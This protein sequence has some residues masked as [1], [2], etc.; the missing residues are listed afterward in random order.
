MLQYSVFR[1]VKDS[2]V[3]GIRAIR[4]RWKRR[5]N[6]RDFCYDSRT[7]VYGFNLSWPLPTRL[8]DLFTSSIDFSSFRADTGTASLS[9]RL[10]NT[11]YSDDVTFFFLAYEQIIK[12]LIPNSL[13]KYTK[14]SIVQ[15]FEFKRRE[16]KNRKCCEL[17]AHSWMRHE[18]TIRAIAATTST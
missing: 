11:Q 4:C 17:W 9:T 12:F 15:C 16:K 14:A 7:H 18:A 10:K 5:A 13:Y 1:R 2:L 8:F 6:S 3:I